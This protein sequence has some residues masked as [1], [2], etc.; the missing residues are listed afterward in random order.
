VFV[1]VIM[2]LA[3]PIIAT[4]LLFIALVDFLANWGMK[5]LAAFTEAALQ[6]L[7]AAIKIIILV[8]A[9]LILALTLLSMIL[10][11]LILLTVF[12]LIAVV[13]NGT[14]SSGLFFFSILNTNGEEFKYEIT[15]EWIYVD[16]I[17]LD[18]PYTKTQTFYNQ[19]VVA[20]NKKPILLGKPEQSSNKLNEPN[21]NSELE[22]TEVD[23]IDFYN[24]MYQG[25]GISLGIISISVGLYIILTKTPYASLA[26][27]IAIASLVVIGVI[28][29]ISILNFCS[30]LPL[31]PIELLCFILGVI[32]A[33]IIGGS[34]M[35]LIFGSTQSAYTAELMSKGLEYAKGVL[36]IIKII[37]FL[38]GLVFSGQ[39]TELISA[40]LNYLI[41]SILSVSIFAIGFGLASKTLSDDQKNTL[42]ITG[43]VLA[44]IGIIFLFLFILSLGRN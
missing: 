19:Q 9:Y 12:F 27:F 33:L 16:F 4:I 2:F 32:F 21:I 31:T 18:L 3:L 37:I 40:E 25:F 42:K 39:E 20:T 41:F 15:I 34:I 36:I 29:V 26:K 17:D 7:E 22:P 14:L 1:T 43:L 30:T 28:L 38:L 8:L 44:I 35:T 6:V 24:R 10:L 23:P 11:F 13:T 5:F